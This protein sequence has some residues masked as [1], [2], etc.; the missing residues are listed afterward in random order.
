MNQ[1]VYPDLK[2]QVALVTGASR[3]IGAAIARAL[4]C[5]G[6]I[7]G[8]LARNEER[9]DSI[10]SEI[11]SDGGHAFPI[12]AD[13]AEPDHMI[14]RV[15]AFQADAGPITLLVNNAGVT[16]DQLL[17]GLKPDDWET[18]LNINLTG[19][20]HIT[21]HV[22]R[23]MLKQRKGS[24][25]NISSVVALMGNPGQVNYVAAKAGLIGFTKALAREVASRNIRVNAVAPGF[26]D[27]AMTA[28][29][30]DET[31]RAYMKQIPLG[32]FGTPE[33]VAQ[34]V[35]FLLSEAS[36][37]ITGTVINISGGLYM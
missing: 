15:R 20:Y 6:A 29:L 32:R 1:P 25:V 31:R 27:T 30:P 23:D 11:V 7:V 34:T 13:L 12:I 37:Y 10:A 35:L 9:L 28:N 33:D 4:A 21:R 19:V 22:L 5:Q 26:I 18:V 3:G 8:L 16:R 14:E 24:I 2:S 17:L 36:A